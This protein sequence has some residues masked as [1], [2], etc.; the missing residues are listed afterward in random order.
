MNTLVENKDRV[1]IVQPRL[2]LPVMRGVIERRML[3][4]FRCEPKALARLLPA[5]F[6]PKLIRGYGMAGICFIRLG[7]VR[8]SFLPASMGLK[9]E[10]AAHRI[11]VEWDDGEAVHE[12]VFIPR[13]DTSSC[14][15]QFAGGWLFPGEHHRADYKVWETA[16]RFKVE[17]RAEDGGAFVRV[18][19]R[20]CDK[21]ASGSI[22]ADLAEASQFFRAG[23]LGWSARAKAGEYD[24]LELHSEEWRVEP[25]TVER[26]ESS[27]FGDRK[28]FPPGTATFDSAFLMRNIA[29]EWRARGRMICEGR[30]E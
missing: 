18:A 7:E 11:A 5:P 3:V 12:G 1:H 24:G 30:H 20:L 2:H 6:R 26:V 13:R 4:N 17:L 14:L 9:S 21:L 16:E 27:F 29:H 15:N 22:F 28:L 23:S 10:N 8:P 25:L 19:A